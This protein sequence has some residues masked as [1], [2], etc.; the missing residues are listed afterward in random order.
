MPIPAISE[1]LPFV[2]IVIKQTNNP[3]SITIFTNAIKV[4]YIFTDFETF[5]SAKLF[6]KFMLSSAALQKVPFIEKCAR[7]M[8][9]EIKHTAT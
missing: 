4:S 6:Y 5:A 2:T 8:I 7:I 1:K 9:Y 3:V